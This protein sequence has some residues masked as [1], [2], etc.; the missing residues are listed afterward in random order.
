MQC[1]WRERE[2]EPLFLVPFFDNCNFRYIIIPMKH[3][4]KFLALPLIL[5]SA[6]A[7]AAGFYLQEQSVSNQGLAYAGAGAHPEDAST[8]FYNPAGLT[9]LSGRQASANV[10]AITPQ[11]KFRDT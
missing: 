11:A 8:I 6:P 9:D 1:M 7:Q 10:S 4:F 2:S 5:L 3:S